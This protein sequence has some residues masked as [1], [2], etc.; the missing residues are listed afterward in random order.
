MDYTPIV[1][2]VTTATLYFMPA[3]F[4]LAVLLGFLRSARFKGWLGE[5][6]VNT[7]LRLWLNK[8]QYHMLTDITLPDKN[9]DTT[10][11]DHIVLSCYG[12]FVVETKNMQGWIFGKEKQKQWTQKIYKKSFKFQNPLHQNYRHTKTLNEYLKLE[13]HQLHSVVVFTGTAELKNEMP[14]NVLQS[15]T[16]VR[17]IKSF[18]EEVLAQEQII[19]IFDKIEALRLERSMKTNRLHRK[20]LE[21]RHNTK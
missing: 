20:S 2:Q 16:V 1:S 9:G 13:P 17:Y 10:Q 14:E 6:V 3:L 11:I 15:I 8:S 21:A 5:F 7:A 19:D 18:K 4:L 12:I